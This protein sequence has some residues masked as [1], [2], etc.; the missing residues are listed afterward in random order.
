MTTTATV[1]TGSAAL[2]PGVLKT[3]IARI[4]QG[5]DRPLSHS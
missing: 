2:T 4:R 1:S 3:Q 5:F